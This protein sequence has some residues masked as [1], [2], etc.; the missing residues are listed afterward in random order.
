ML[1][2]NETVKLLPAVLA[3][4]ATP[5]SVLTTLSAINM[6]IGGFETLLDE[7]EAASGSPPVIC[8][9]EV[10]VLMDWFEGVKA[11][12]TDLNALLRFFVQVGC[13]LVAALL[14]V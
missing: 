6:L 5:T 9:D 10:D 14:L 13:W 8:I 11:L 3:A 2:G 1:D 7:R 12:Q 4:S